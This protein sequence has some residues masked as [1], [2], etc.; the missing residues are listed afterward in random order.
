MTQTIA[1][2]FPPMV[3]KIAP[4]VEQYSPCRCGCGANPGLLLLTWDTV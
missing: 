3:T 4:P 2:V 1:V